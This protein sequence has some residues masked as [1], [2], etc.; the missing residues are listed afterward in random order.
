[1]SAAELAQLAEEQAA[2]R[3]VA[4]L[5]ARGTAQEELFAAVTAEVGQL[6]PVEFALM[7]RYEADDTVMS[8]AAWGSPVARFPIG[9]RWRLGGKNLATIVR[10]T[11]RPGR[12]DHADGSS[13]SIGAVGRES[14][15]RSTV[16]APIVV[17]GRVWGAMTVGSMRVEPPLPVG[18]EDRLAQFTDLLATAIA[19]AESRAGLAQLGEEQE[20]LRRVATL[21][22]RGVPQEE[23]FAAVTDEVARLFPTDLTIMHRYDPNG[24]ITIVGSVDSV[25]SL[26]KHWS[27]GSR[28]PL[29]G[30]NVGMLVFE[31]ARPA[32]I[33]NAEASGAH[34]DQAR[35]DGVRST[36][37][38]PIL[39]EGRVWGLMGLV[40]TREEPLPADSEARLA[41][42]TELVATAIANAES[43]AGLA[44]L[45]EEQAA[46]RLVATLVA[47]GTPP[48]QLF[49]AVT[50]EIGRLLC[51]ECAIMNRYEPDG[52][53]TTMAGWGDLV[54]GFPVGHRESLGGKNVITLVHQTGRPARIDRYADSSSGSIG[55]VGREIGFSSAVGAPIVV[56]GRLWGLVAVAST[57]PEPPLSADT[58]ARVASFTELVATAIANA[59]SHA[60]LARLAEEQAALHRVA[61][62]VA[63]GALP[64]KV[65]AAVTEEVERLFVAEMTRMIR[66]DQDGTFTVVGTSGMELMTVGS[67][68]P[69]GGKN[70]AALVFE[71]AGPARVDSFVEASGPPYIDQARAVGLRSSVGVPI[72]V[73]G[74]VWGLMAVATSRAE[75]LP[76]DTEARLASFTELVATAIANAESRTGLARLAEEQAALR[77]VATLVARGTPPEKLF[78]AVADEAKRLLP[79][80]FAHMGR[81]ESDGTITFVAASGATV[82]RFPVGARLRLGGRNIC[83]I[84]F[85]TGRPGRVDDYPDASGP[86]GVA[87]RESGIRSAAGTPI[88]V[89]DHVWGVMI[90]GS[91]L[92]SILPPDTEARL[93]GFTD[94][95]AMAIANAKS[96]AALRPVERMRAQAERITELQ[97]SERLSVPDAADEVA[98]L[99]LT[100]NEM[101][102]RVELAV[103]RERRVVS[104]ASHE[105]RTPLTTLRAEVDLALMG[106]RDKT[107]LRAALESASEEARRMS[108][109]ADDLL[110][111]ARADQGR[112]PLHPQ[113]LA[114]LGLLEDAARRARAG[115]EVRGRSIAVAELADACAVSADPDRAAQVLDNLIANALLYGD[116]TITLSAQSKQ[117]YVELHV[118]DQGDGFP[119]ELLSRAFER[120]GRGQHA[121]ANEPGSGLGLALVEAVALAHGGRAEVRNR[122]AGGADVSFTLPR[123]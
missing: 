42:F 94:L 45:A 122:P 22:A 34:I 103:A 97:L 112:L 81:Y 58:E 40:T 116:G 96:R 73:E 31:T 65:F 57:M 90:A 51:V 84:V 117:G 107:E 78:V 21:V 56:E 35:E 29:G 85:E 24:T 37:G 108:R 55:A 114:A 28:W 100:L 38:V 52:T 66:Y 16:G 76:A 70:L 41:G 17:E 119:E 3:R 49:A 79:V 23:V 86:L 6:L 75:P 9:R 36:V 62:L 15:F 1:L 64:E 106:D 27:V 120:F 69:V 13:G 44:R 101:L 8:I 105:L 77:R 74:R 99:G 115:A 110:V 30:K 33:E 118:T 93:A 98:A 25:G 88:I 68:W 63:R 4:T 83:T 87:G 104:D 59:E 7:G 72:V 11:G 5:V 48:E 95:M 54:A 92:E 67:R 26:G 2:L 61:T 50:E 111:L 80:N 18:I 53:I 71:T 10:E 60:A 82:G 123:A 46:L 102:D 14:G 39:V 109:L 89:E 12:V 91:T 43:R 121:R 32:R 47:R 19:N 113:P 20:A